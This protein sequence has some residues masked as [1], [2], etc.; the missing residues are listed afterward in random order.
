MAYISNFSF[1]CLLPCISLFQTQIIFCC[2]FFFPVY[3]L[4]LFFL[5]ML[6]ILGG[7]D[8]ENKFLRVE[9]MK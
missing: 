8:L 6:L 4:H 7:L 1:S 9:E 5:T 2:G 3:S